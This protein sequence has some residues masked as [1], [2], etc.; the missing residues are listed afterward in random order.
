MRRKTQDIDDDTDNLDSYDYY[1]FYLNVSRSFGLI[2]FILTMC[3][4][5]ALVLV[6]IQPDWIGDTDES[7]SRGYFGIY[8]F[9]VRSNV[10]HNYDCSGEWNDFD[11]FPDDTSVFKASNVFILIAIILS[12]CVILIS[13]VSLCVKFER[14]FHICSWIQF[15]ISKFK[16]LRVIFSFL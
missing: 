4:T 7:A 13:F 14:I 3:F 12:M 5:V 9:C 15:I 16:N 2:W 1:K 6:Y 8:R 10:F 11:R